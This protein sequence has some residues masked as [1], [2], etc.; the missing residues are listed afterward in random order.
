MSDIFKSI[1]TVQWYCSSY[2]DTVKVYF[3]SIES[4]IHA[5]HAKRLKLTGLLM[6]AICVNFKLSFFYWHNI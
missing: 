6:L 4:F 3:F 1:F 5:Y 2:Q